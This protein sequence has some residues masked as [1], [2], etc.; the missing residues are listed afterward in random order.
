MKVNVKTEIGPFDGTPKA[1][2]LISTL[3]ALPEEA[4]VNIQMQRS[5]REGDSW[6]ITANWTEER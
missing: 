6:T 5:Q 1:K 4:Y 3:S 2:D